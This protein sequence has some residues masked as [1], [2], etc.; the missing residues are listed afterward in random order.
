MPDANGWHSANFTGPDGHL[1]RWHYCEGADTDT[2]VL[3]TPEAR[4]EHELFC[5][6][7]R[8]TEREKRQRERVRAAADRLRRESPP[9]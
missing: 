1:Y 7:R 3:D 2:L 4:R 8:K 6:R 9:G 5:Q